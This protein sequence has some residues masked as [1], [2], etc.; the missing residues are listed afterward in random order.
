[1]PTDRSEDS[2]EARIDHY[3][4]SPLG[5]ALFV[6]SDQF[7]QLGLDPTTARSLEFYVTESG[8]QITS[9]KE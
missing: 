5:V 3:D 6:D 7:E 2:R 9:K 8:I 1:M 4:G